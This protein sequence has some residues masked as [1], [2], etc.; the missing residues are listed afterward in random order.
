MTDSF[1][2]LL[3]ILPRSHRPGVVHAL[4]KRVRACA[5]LIDGSCTVENISIPGLHAS[6]KCTREHIR[7]TSTLHRYEKLKLYLLTLHAPLLLTDPEQ[8]RESIKSFL[9]EIR[10]LSLKYQIERVV[11]STDI[12]IKYRFSDLQL[13]S[14]FCAR[15][16]LQPIS[17]I[18]PL[19]S[20]PSPDVMM[21][22]FKGM[23]HDDLELLLKECEFKEIV[24][25]LLLFVPGAG[26]GVEASYL[27]AVD[28]ELFRIARTFCNDNE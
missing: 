8:S 24:S 20:A 11:I 5:S 4:G 10:D 14:S 6:L 12:D 15:V 22:A 7:Y 2:T 23:E 9:K 21:A 18:E 1:V 19:E 13:Q 27:E 26:E 3:V 16:A 25:L 28:P 17:G